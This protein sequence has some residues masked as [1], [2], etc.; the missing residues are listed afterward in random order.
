M[1][2]IAVILSVCILLVT[3]AAIAVEQP[4]QM[5]TWPKDFSLASD[6]H[7]IFGIPNPGSGV[8]KVSISW[9]GS[10]L[11]IGATGS[12][13]TVVAAPVTKSSPSYEFSIKADGVDQA[14]CPVFLVALALP[15]QMR[16]K[17]SGKISV[18]S[19]PVEPAKFQ[20]FANLTR[21]QSAAGA[22]VIQQQQDAWFASIKAGLTA[23]I[24]AQ[25]TE[26]TN[27]TRSLQTTA[28]T[29]SRQINAAVGSLARPGTGPRVAAWRVTNVLKGP[30][31]KIRIPA[32]QPSI[33]TV[34]P[35]QGMSG[36]PVTI[37]GVGLNENATEVYFTIA[38]GV[39]VSANVLSCTKS[40]NGVATILAQV[41]EKA[42]VTAAYDGQVYAKAADWE[43]A[44]ATN[45]LAFHFEPIV[46]PSITYIDPVEVGPQAIVNIDGNN[47]TNGDMIHFVIPGL[48]DYAVNT[49][50]VN[51]TRL[52]AQVPL[53]TSRQIGNGSVYVAKKTPT[54]SV[55]SQGQSMIFKPTVPL[56]ISIPAS[57]VSENP[58]LIRG[59]SFGTTGEVH[60]IDAVGVDTLL[61]V[62]SWS[63][64]HITVRTPSAVGFTGTKPY[65]IYVK[66]SNG[67]SDN[68]PFAITPITDHVLMQMAELVQSKDYYVSTSGSGYCGLSSPNN[69]TNV[70][71]M[72]G[73]H[74]AGMFDG[75]KGDDWFFKSRVLKNG[76]T[77]EKIDF[78]P[79]LATEPC[80]GAGLRLERDYA[81]YYGSSSP[82]V[83]VHWWVDAMWG[84]ASYSFSITI[85]GPKGTA[86]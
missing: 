23:K 40:S 50:F 6:E 47:F 57:E 86:Y 66:N 8:I 33:S 26:K 59:M 18:V 29:E 37:T 2:R 7:V 34:N 80:G 44:Y 11:T 71:W 64:T 54:G 55:N 28:Q 16:A 75:H 1:N 72:Y 24:K 5:P 35:A 41:P 17:A 43:P 85:Q 56:V 20:Q 32:T 78:K 38:P 81:S 62:D 77:V 39:D 69:N 9:T 68:Q 51:G 30:K 45:K 52:S 65:N 4:L 79:A 58:I 70:L 53:Y 36:A 60:A 3:S 27:K 61:P 67:K 74:Q 14:K 12:D 76:W 13:K 42:G 25:Q 10:P 19:P 31:G 84:M 48:Q 82:Y 21:Q 63:D 46:A 83:P 73:R 22:T 15:K 49:T